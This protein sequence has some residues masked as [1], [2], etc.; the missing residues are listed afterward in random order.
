M[1]LA[2]AGNG[3]SAR[4]AAGRRKD[5]PREGADLEDQRVLGHH[6]RHRISSRG[7]RCALLRRLVE[8]LVPVG[9]VD[10]T[11]EDVPPLQQQRR[12]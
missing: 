5:A 11:V 3:M 2:R 12:E 10:H 7:W 6:A 4:A 1:S 8:Q 9:L